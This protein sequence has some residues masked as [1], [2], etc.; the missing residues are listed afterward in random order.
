MRRFVFFLLTL[1]CALSLSPSGSAF[2]QAAA[3][4]VS[5]QKVVTRGG[6]HENFGRIVFDWQQPVKHTAQIEGTRLTI[7]FDRPMKTVLGSVRRNLSAYISRVAVGPDGRSI[8]ATLNGTY[9]LRSFGRG[10]RIVIDLLR[11][12]ANDDPVTEIDVAAALSSSG[13]PVQIEEP[14]ATKKAR[15]RP[16][17]LRRRSTAKNHGGKATV[18]AAATVIVRSGRHAGYGRL[19]FEWSDRVG[20]KL[21][22]KGQTVS[23]RF[24]RPADIDGKRLRRILPPQISSAKARSTT[25]GLNVRLGIPEGGQIR[26]FRDGDSVV[27]DVMGSAV[28]SSRRAVAGAASDAKSRKPEPAADTKKAKLPPTPVTRPP[29][30]LGKAKT[31]SQRARELALKRRIEKAKQQQS[32]PGALVTVDTTRRGEEISI[33]FNWREKTA[34]AVYRRD[35][36]LWIVFDRAIR[37][38]LASVTQVGKPV[39]ETAKQLS[40]PDSSVL[41]LSMSKPQEI[42]VTRDE[43]A[44]V[45]DVGPKAKPPGPAVQVETKYGGQ[46]GTRVLITAKEMGQAIPLHDPDVGDLAYMIP[47]GAPGLGNPTARKYLDFELM[48]SAQGLAIRPVAED[49]SVRGDKDQVTVSRRGGLRITPNINLAKWQQPKREKIFDFPSWRI[50]PSDEYQDVEY[51]LMAQV[52]TSHGLARNAAR[53]SL[54][55]F[56]VAHGMGAEALGVLRALVRQ[57]PAVM[58]DHKVRALRGVAAYQLRH[59]AEA[60]SDLEHY[61][62]R[63]NPEI[64]LWLAG[65]AAARGDWAGAYRWF[66]DTDPVIKTYPPEMATQFAILAAE[67][68]LS[69]E[70]DNSGAGRLKELESAVVTEPQA[71]HIAYLQG[72]LAKKS[73]DFPK[74][75]QLWEAVAV[76]GDRPS[77]AKAAFALTTTL[78]EKGDIKPEEAIDKLEA[79]RF[80]WRDD[81]FEF[82]LLQRLGR[83]Y[84]EVKD[85][86]KALLTFRRAATY[87]SHIK[88]SQ[89]LTAQMSTVFRKYYTDGDAD[90]QMPIS[91]LGIYQE[92][93]ELTPSGEEGDR[94]ISRLAERLVKVDLLAQAGDLLEHQMLFRIKGQEKAAVGSR[95]A[96]VRIMERLS[97]KALE[98]LAKSEVPDIPEPLARKRTHLKAVALSKLGRHDA[99]LDTVGEDESYEA[100]RLRADILWGAKRWRQASR[101]LARLTGGLSQDK[102]SNDNA[103]LLLRRAVALALSNDLVGI[104]FLRGRFGEAME[105]SPDAKAFKAVVGKK[106]IETDDYRVLARTASEL[107]VFVAFRRSDRAQ[108]QRSSPAIN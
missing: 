54:A 105:K 78:L 17:R 91:A 98:A 7:G 30:R 24:N 104:E 5:P 27:L 60:A 62:L 61:A 69:V 64:H 84:A 4:A 45:V 89:G 22:R 93:K 94:L 85:Y 26:H 68:S 43:F 23:I 38:D 40:I 29:E 34:A 25:T 6:A 71:D 33:R 83:L 18:P 67:A 86:R 46:A 52:T 66:E 57:N 87:Y 75:L 95:L 8:T 32:I 12:K 77:R 107:D 101:M 88:G 15:S 82:D 102:V 63:R 50:G 42:A 28:A 108:A 9:S 21:D 37:I 56:Y 100:D 92:F 41:R 53:L 36:I 70:D 79:L 90:K 97:E 19:V 16:T 58:R 20:Y 44:W 51:Q 11:R 106:K 81:V 55:R 14:P 59:F 10:N 65:I 72:F 3:P 47:L 49:L 35:N 99:A 103:R 2:A 31:L 39:F 76:M 48:P 80:A 74:A 96:E 73:G 1:G 13:T